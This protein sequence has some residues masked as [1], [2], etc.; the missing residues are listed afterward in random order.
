MLSNMFKNKI[1]LYKRFIKEVYMVQISINRWN[2]IFSG[3]FGFMDI[4]LALTY[5]QL[6]LEQKLTVCG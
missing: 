5:L 2:K 6:I 3:P 4:H 1:I